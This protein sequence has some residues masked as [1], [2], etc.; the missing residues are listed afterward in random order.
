MTDANH[1]AN[2]NYECHNCNINLV[3]IP[4]YEL[5]NNLWK[6][7]QCGNDIYINATLKGENQVIIRKQAKNIKHNDLVHI[8]G[9]TFSGQIYRV[10]GITSQANGK[11]A[12]GLAAY[13]RINVPQEKFMNTITGSF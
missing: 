7:P 1:Y 10:L 2:E 6:C 8:Q 4:A 11:I 5:Y 13:T 3:G 9:A 12:I